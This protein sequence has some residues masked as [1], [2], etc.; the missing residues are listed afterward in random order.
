VTVWTWLASICGAGGL[1][2]LVYLAIDRIQARG[3]RRAEIRSRLET[4][5]RLGK[6][7]RR[8]REHAAEIDAARRALEDVA[9]TRV[10]EGPTP[11][12]L[13]ELHAR[14]REPWPPKGRR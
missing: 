7:E 1:A 13:A 14:T 9:A 3:A 11:R 10:A 12:N 8:D 2:A 5:R 4:G 6:I